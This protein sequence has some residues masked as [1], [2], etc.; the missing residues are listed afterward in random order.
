MHVYLIFNACITC[1]TYVWCDDYDYDRTMIP[2]RTY[3]DQKISKFKSFFQPREVLFFDCLM[4]AYTVCTSTH[5]H[6]FALFV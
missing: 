2:D 1:I 4:S 3:E 6:A 5:Q